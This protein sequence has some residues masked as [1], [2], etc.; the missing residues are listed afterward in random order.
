MKRA[1]MLL[2]AV[3]ALLLGGCGGVSKPAAIADLSGLWS[4]QIS[5]SANP[6]FDLGDL[7]GASN[8]LYTAFSVNIAQS[9]PG[10]TI[11]P[12]MPAITTTTTTT[13]LPPIQLGSY[14][15]FPSESGSGS[16]SGSSLA[17]TMTDASTSD[18]TSG[19]VLAIHGTFTGSTVQGTYSASNT[20]GG[21]SCQLTS[22]TVTMTLITPSPTPTP[23]P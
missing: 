11:S 9:G 16:I 17:L 1:Q 20:A 13:P 19:C 7:N 12:W 10:L 3:A 2:L 4:V 8:L 22:G 14:I 5:Y 18:T 15:T 23:T 6:A 21:S